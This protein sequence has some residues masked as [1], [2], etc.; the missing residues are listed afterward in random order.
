MRR[1]KGMQQTHLTHTQC[2]V[3]NADVINGTIIPSY[4]F[5]RVPANN[6][7]TVTLGDI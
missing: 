5:S 1:L 2:T 6:G 3:V 7:V 4:V